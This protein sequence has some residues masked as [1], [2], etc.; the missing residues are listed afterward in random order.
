MIKCLQEN[1][2]ADWLFS[3]AFG[4]TSTKFR[5][6][7]RRRSS[8]GRYPMNSWDIPEWLEEEVR[9]RDTT[10][11]YCR[12]QMMEQTPRRGPRRAAATW[13]HIINDATIVTRENIARCCAACNSSKGTKSLA[14]WIESSYCRTRGITTDTV[15]DVV[16]QA[17]RASARAARPADRRESSTSSRWVATHQSRAEHESMAELGDLAQSV[18]RR[19]HG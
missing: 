5:W 12:I 18:R 13:E 11:V 14:E 16:K 17:L 2:I 8:I 19:G 4:G 10:C 1:N 15:A 3:A 6:M 9:A 7:R